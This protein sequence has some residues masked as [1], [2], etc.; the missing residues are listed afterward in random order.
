MSETCGAIIEPLVLALR[1]RA[2]L[3]PVQIIGGNGSAALLDDRTRIDL[4]ARTIEAPADCDLPRFRPDGSL[5]DLDALALSTDQAEVDRVEALAEELVDG[6]LLVS[7]F[8]LK[9]VADLEQQR[10][11]PLRSAARVFLGDRY[12][13][14]VRDGQGGIV[15]IDGVKSLYPF[16]VPIS[17]DTFETFQ[18]SIGG[19][20]ATPTAHPGATILNYLTRSI[21]GIRAKD[22]DKVEAMTGNVLTRYPGVRQWILDGPGRDSFDLARVLHTLG[23]SR[24]HP[25]V[26]SLGGQLDI[27]PYRLGELRRHPGFMAADLAAGVQRTIVEVSHLKG[28]AL[29]RFESSPTIVTFWQKHIEERVR[30]V[31]H[32]EL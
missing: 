8:G 5:R 20:V 31:I 6:R 14:I 19:G 13:T 28:L 24:R 27:V 22:F 12:V 7:V 32:N 23:Q 21:S 16:Q 15:G 18:L 3:P 26:L 11:Q 25:R 4:E 2:D 29:A 9:T 1:G 17:T 10:R 30:A